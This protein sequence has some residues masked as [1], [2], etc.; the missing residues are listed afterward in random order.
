MGVECPPDLPSGL[1]GSGLRATHIGIQAERQRRLSIE[2]RTD[3]E[4]LAHT[5]S[6]DFFLTI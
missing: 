4:V 6:E 2:Y 1:T 5:M 3:N